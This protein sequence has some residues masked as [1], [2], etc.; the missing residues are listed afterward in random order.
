MFSFAALEAN[1]AG[2]V[3]QES[4]SEETLAH[5]GQHGGESGSTQT[6][7]QSQPNSQSE[8]L[9]QTDESADT[10]SVNMLDVL[11]NPV[12]VAKNEALENDLNNSVPVLSQA[13]LLGFI[14]C[15]TILGERGENCR[16]KKKVLVKSNDWI[17]KKLLVL[18]LSKKVCSCFLMPW[19]IT[20]CI[21]QYICL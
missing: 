18:L 8:M 12:S 2:I 1:G 9:L 6:S 11:N 10:H 19:Y 15:F 7:L 14:F 5:I 17:G 3:L 20:F 16:L 4:D 21:W 13:V